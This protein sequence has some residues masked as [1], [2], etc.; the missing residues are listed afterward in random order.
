MAPPPPINCSHE[1]T[2]LWSP[3]H[4]ERTAMAVLATFNAKPSS[5]PSLC[6]MTRSVNPSN[7]SLAHTSK[8]EAR[9]QRFPAM[10]DGLRTRGPCFCGSWVLNFKDNR[11]HPRLIALG[12][13]LQCTHRPM[14]P[15]A[16]CPCGILSSSRA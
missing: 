14:M 13:A 1:S 12:T 15:L 11:Y 10:A 6:S 2:A 4:V 9:S 7:R 8:P 16:S 3:L 5:Q